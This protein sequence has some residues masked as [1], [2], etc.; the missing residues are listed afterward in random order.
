MMRKMSYLSTWNREEGI[1]TINLLNATETQRRGECER[2]AH[3]VLIRN[4]VYFSLVMIINVHTYDVSHG[5]ASASAAIAPSGCFCCA[6]ILVK[7]KLLVA[8]CICGNSSGQCLMCQKLPRN[9]ATTTTNAK[10]NEKNSATTILSANDRKMGS[11]YVQCNN[12][13]VSKYA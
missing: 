9:A 4:A 12:N 8:I 2:T 3:F 6:N 7:F 13:I 11:N 5:L 1:M 10:M